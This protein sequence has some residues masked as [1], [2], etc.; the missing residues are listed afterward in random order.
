MLRVG[1][2]S[3]VSQHSA[4]PTMNQGTHPDGDL[5]G[6]EEWNEGIRVANF[7]DTRDI[8]IQMKFEV[9]T[10]CKKCDGM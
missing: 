3:H 1:R 8:M 2:T 7:N 4:S 6:S 9:A 10:Y 5:R